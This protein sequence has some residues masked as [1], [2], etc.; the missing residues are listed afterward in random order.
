MR[1]FAGEAIKRYLDQFGLRGSAW[2]QRLRVVG[3]TERDFSVLRSLAPLMERHAERLAQ[4]L[5]DHLWSFEE[6]RALVTGSNNTRERLQESQ[7][8]AMVSIFQPPYG[9]EFISHRLTV[10]IL[11]AWGGIPSRWYLTAH[12]QCEFLIQRLLFRHYVLRPW[13]ILPAWRAVSR[14]MG[15]EKELVLEAYAESIADRFQS[16]TGQVQGTANEVLQTAA[17]LES[18]TQQVSGAMQQMASAVQ[19][20]AR[21][22]AEQTSAVGRTSTAISALVTRVDGVAAGAESQA[23]GVTEATEAMAQVRAG[24]D[25]VAAGAEQVAGAA[26]D[27]YQAALQGATAVNEATQGMARIRSA[28]EATAARVRELGARSEQIGSIIE[29]I[30]DIAEQTNLLA[31]NAAIEAARAGEA[32]K[33][34]AVVAEEV[35]KLAERSGQAT[36]EI[37]DL[38]RQVQQETESA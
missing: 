7:R 24:V 18:I 33:G 17:N 6:F 5:Y 26:H 20:V 32:G 37:A 38:I 10:G 12:T 11:Y 1:D 19:E 36:K 3:L 14:A 4:E 31:L 13:R 25:E 28:V 15:L 35:R 16:L 30:D 23:H 29:V 22:T 2:Q 8:R 27:A 34:F 21:G 9:E